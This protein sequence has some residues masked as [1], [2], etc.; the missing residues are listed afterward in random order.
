MPICRIKTGERPSESRERN[1]AVHHWIFFNICG[2][3]E[4]DE[5]MPDY[6]RVNPERHHYQTEHDEKIRSSERARVTG[7]ESFR[8]SSLGCDKADSFSLF[9]LPFGHSVCQEDLTAPR[10]VSL[11]LPVSFCWRFRETDLDAARPQIPE[12]SRAFC[13]WRTE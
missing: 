2:V 7:P 1:A 6:L 13:R 9:R 11:G 10:P 8:G 4:S 3:I 5:L 12:C